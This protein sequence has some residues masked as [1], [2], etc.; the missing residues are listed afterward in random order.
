MQYKV[1]LV[2]ESPKINTTITLVIT[3]FLSDLSLSSNNTKSTVPQRAL[4]I[5][6]LLTLQL[7]HVHS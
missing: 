4:L 3:M 7:S 2:I 6:H 5:P 1:S